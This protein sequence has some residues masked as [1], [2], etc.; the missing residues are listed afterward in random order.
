MS[1]THRIVGLSMLALAT[2]CNAEVRTQDGALTRGTITASDRDTLHM[3]D[4][5]KIGPAESPTDASASEPARFSRATVD[6]AEV[7]DIDH[8]GNVLMVTGGALTA[9]FTI[10]TLGIALSDPPPPEPESSCESP[11]GGPA[12]FDLDLDTRATTRM[13]LGVAVTGIGVGLALGVT[14][15]VQYTRSVSAARPR[16]S[17]GPGSV[18]ISGGF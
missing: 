2:G 13:S 16:V 18:S 3:V 14:G 7:V 17:V 15:L 11:H 8:P 9:Y 4:G 6:R 12:C 1:P 5:V 10:V